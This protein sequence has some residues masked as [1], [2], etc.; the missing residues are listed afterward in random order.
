MEANE[1]VV[2]EQVKALMGAEV[3]VVANGG[4]VQGGIGSVGDILSSKGGTNIGAL[5]SALAANE[6]V[7]KFVSGVVET[8]KK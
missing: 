8:I 5:V 7:Q 1:T 4:S 2:V 3:K 6:D